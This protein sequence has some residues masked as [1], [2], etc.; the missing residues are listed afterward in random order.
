MPEKERET[1]K[2]L[3]IKASELQKDLGNNNYNKA[4]FLETIN[5]YNY[6]DIPYLS[7]GAATGFQLGGGARFFFEQNFFRN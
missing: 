7:S 3:F 2:D 4:P 5:L 1:E 6:I